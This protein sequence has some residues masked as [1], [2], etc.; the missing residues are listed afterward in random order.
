M[1]LVM[2]LALFMLTNCKEKGKAGKK[3]PPLPAQDGLVLYSFLLR[4]IPE[5]VSQ[6][7]CSCCNRNL[8]WCY[9]G[10]CPPT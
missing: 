9:K 5:V 1:I 2:L 8:D 10:G 6:V 7:P 4:E 3:L